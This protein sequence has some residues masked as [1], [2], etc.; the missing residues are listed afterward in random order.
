MTRFFLENLNAPAGNHATLFQ[1]SPRLRNFPEDYV[2][3][4]M[5]NNGGEGFLGESEYLILWPIEAI[6]HLNTAYEVD[7]YAPGLVL[8]GSSGGGEAYAF[9]RRSARAA[10]VEVPFVG[11]NL[12]LASP[13]SSSFTDFLEQLRQGWSD[14]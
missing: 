5:N 14:K 9:D 2:A 4:M 11:M 13:I 10:I 7:E 8:F 6:D 1:T 12:D 3:F